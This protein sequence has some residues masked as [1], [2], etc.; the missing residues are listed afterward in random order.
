VLIVED[1]ADAQQTLRMLLEDEGHR[2]D[3]A[4]DGPSGLAR[5]AA[6]PFDIVL[7][8]IGLPV[9]DGYEL[10][11]RI[12]ACSARTILVAISG[13]GQADDRQRSLEAGFDAHLT[14]PVSPDQLSVVLATL[15][16]NRR[17]S[18]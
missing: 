17:R 3:V 14:K 9:M 16:R 1:N 15:F 7:V 5:V 2:V 6:T 11:R 10:A 4:A 8:D 12:R 18:A 13:Y